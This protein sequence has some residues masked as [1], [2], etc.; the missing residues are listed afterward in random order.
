MIVATADAAEAVAQGAAV[1]PSSTAAHAAPILIVRDDAGF[2]RRAMPEDRLLDHLTAPW[3]EEELVARVDAWVRVRRALL[4]SDPAN[5]GMQRVKRRLRPRDRVADLGARIAAVL[6]R[7]VPRLRKPI[8]P[9]LEVAARLADWADR[10]DAF[11]AGHAERVAS[12]CAL[13]GRGLRLG[14]EETAS[15]LRAAMLHDIGK[16]GLP[17]AMLHQRGPL[18]DDQM[19]LM[20]QHPQRGA[21]LLRLLD[22]ERDVADAVLFHH[23]RPDGRGYYGREGESVPRAARILAVAEVYDAM[24]SSTLQPRCTPAE[25]LDGLAR[26]RGKELDGECVD[27]LID[28]LRPRRAYTGF[29]SRPS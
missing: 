9:Y 1:P 26:R 27:A 8:G 11:A 14:D 25:A 4:V 23:E 16:A 21:A 20:R 15:L 13:I 12:L 18:R 2:S 10:R 24:T 5:G 19:R 7:R 6:Q 17:H 22:T 28:A 3:S 29:G